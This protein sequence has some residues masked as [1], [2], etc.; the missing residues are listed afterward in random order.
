MHDVVSSWSRG[1]V[2][3]DRNKLRIYCARICLIYLRIMAILPS[4]VNSSP[5]VASVFIWKVQPVAF[6]FLF[7]IRVSEK[8]GVA[9]SDGG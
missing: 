1:N 4:I 6:V 3:A 7:A 8:H 9:A 5:D 2:P